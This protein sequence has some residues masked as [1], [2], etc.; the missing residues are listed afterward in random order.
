MLVVREEMKH[1]VLA[2]PA[3]LMAAVPADQEGFSEGAVAVEPQMC[4]RVVMPSATG[5]WWLVVVVV[6]VSIYRAGQG[7]TPMVWAVSLGHRMEE[8]AHKPVVAPVELGT[9]AEP[10][11]LLGHWELA[12]RAA[13]ALC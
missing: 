8:A 13:L 2:V 4:G 6:P 9:T 3:D 10:M 11:E 7:V 12:A 5:S 1:L